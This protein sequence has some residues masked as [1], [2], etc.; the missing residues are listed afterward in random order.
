MDM[1]IAVLNTTSKKFS[2]E[3]QE[4]FAPCP[5][6]MTYQKLSNKDLSLQIIA[7]HT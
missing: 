5:K 2:A 3:S 6:A 7:M 1:Q 4:K